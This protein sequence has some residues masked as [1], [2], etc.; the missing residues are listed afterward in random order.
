MSGTPT[1]DSSAA[2]P[3]K[4]GM[5][6]SPTERTPE[7]W[8]TLVGD[9]ATIAAAAALSRIT[10]LLRI[11][12]A[13]AVLGSTVLG[14]LFVAVNVLPLVLYDI[15]AGSAISS[16]LVPPLVR[17]LDRD[18]RTAA[19][20]FSAN[21]LGLICGAMA[22]VAV[23]A[24][25]GRSLIAAALT[26]GVDP[27][28]ST[29]AVAVGGVLLALIVPQL[30]LYAAIGV[31]VSIQH[32]NRRFFVPSAAPIVENLGLLAT[33]AVAGHR[34]GGGVEVD[35]APLGLILTL[36]IGSGLSV[37]AHALIQ[38]VGAVRALGRLRVGF[39][40]RDTEMG[41][42]VGPARSSFGWSSTIAARQFALVVA[43]GFAGAGGVQAFE[44]ATLAYFIPVALV[45]RPIASAA[46]PRLA[47]SADRPGEL[48]A[49]YRTTLRLAGWLALPAG[50]A[51]VLLSG[52]LAD[53]I[54]QGRFSDAEATRL[55]MFGLAGLGIGATGEALFELA[56]QTLMAYRS[57]VGL[58]GSTWIRAVVAAVGI[59]L[60]VVVLDGA[61]VLLGL[62][63]VVSLG[64]LAAL[65][66]IH[67]VLRADPAWEADESR[68]WP[69][70]VAASA[71][72]L[73]PMAALDQ[74]GGIDWT[75]PG[76]VAL[77]ATVVVL[78]SGGAWLVTGRGRLLQ[79]LT[80]SLSGFV[81]TGGPTAGTR[82]QP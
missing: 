76:F 15:F 81:P 23:G 9:S 7:G 20:R 5:A 78:F 12:V 32:A 50:A 38:L 27:S 45:G 70:I 79:E 75:P 18:D 52:P 59:P 35:G 11:V 77:L 1:A 68:H 29:D 6:G 67:R 26:A 82:A 63:L 80:R 13:A 17:L 54:G 60:V 19:R 16:V 72:A 49:G 62:G 51:L 73:V 43:A 34:Y 14:D 3:P 65:V 55:L 46:L 71:L 28:L 69:R 47:G 44:I 2:E 40:W 21:A 41:R 22:I 39:A 31:F 37:T 36:G 48:L 10:G 56:R 8:P 24:V 64:D 30:V 25:L 74:L 53:V 66:A 4:G 42:L 57:G 61:P 33:I 58:G